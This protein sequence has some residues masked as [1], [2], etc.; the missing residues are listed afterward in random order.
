MQEEPCGSSSEFWRDDRWTCTPH[1]E[2][3][4]PKNDELYDRRKDLFQLKNIL[5]KKPEE[6]KELLRELKLYRSELRTL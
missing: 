5:E 3:I 4:I 6:A 1:S 2:I